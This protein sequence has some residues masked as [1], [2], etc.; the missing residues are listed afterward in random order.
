[1]SV[2]QTFCNSDNETVLSNQGSTKEM[3]LN[4]STNVPLSRVL[5]GLKA[6]KDRSDPVYLGDPLEAPAVFAL[7]E[8]PVRRK[9]YE[10]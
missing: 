1:M 4:R 5:E 6:A 7:Q 9:A 2:Y 8:E 3:I 10:L